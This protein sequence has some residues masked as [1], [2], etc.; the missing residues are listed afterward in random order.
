MTA[1]S[2][3]LMPNQQYTDQLLRILIS[4]TAAYKAKAD[5]KPGC[6]G[7]AGSVPEPGQNKR[8]SLSNKNSSERRNGWAF[9]LMFRSGP[10]GI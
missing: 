10:L 9:L 3:C 6:F 1:V 5:S 2:I 7:C 4:A 8:L